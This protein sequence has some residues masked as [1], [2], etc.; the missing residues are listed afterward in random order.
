MRQVTVHFRLVTPAYLGGADPQNE[1]AELR[2]PSFRGLLRYWLRA[3]AGASNPDI[4]NVSQIEDAT[5]GS[6]QS[7]SPISLW[8]SDE[9]Q[10]KAAPQKVGIG[11]SL[12]QPEEDRLSPE[13]QYLFWSMDRRKKPPRAIAAGTEFAL[14]LALRGGSRSNTLALERAIG[15]LWLLAHLGGM[16]A[17]SRRGA[18]SLM[19]L[20]ITGLPTEAARLPFEPPTSVEDLQS[21]LQLGISAVRSVCPSPPVAPPRPTDWLPSFDIL[22]RGYCRVWILRAPLGAYWDTADDVL[23][24]LGA[25]LRDYRSNLPL[26]ERTVFGLPIIVPNA[27]EKSIKGRRA[28]PLLLRVSSVSSPTDGSEYVA[29]AVLFKSRFQPMA[30]QR[31][32]P[33][34]NYGLIENWTSSHDFTALEVPL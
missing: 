16:G 31:S 13:Q 9:T 1:P 32:E 24:A 23:D 10:P 5:F 27:N 2:I 6:I 25:S 34:P 19:P 17:R 28:S 33:L 18:G 7:A 3:A 20:G 8:F 11:R 30:N 12:A 29:V 14:H 4:A 15:A 26:A 21:R 22:A